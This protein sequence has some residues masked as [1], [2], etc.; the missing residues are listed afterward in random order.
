M[1]AQKTY[2]L[3]GREHTVTYS[4][5]ARGLAAHVREIVRPML[6]A[7]ASKQITGTASSGD[8]TFGIDNAAEQ[9]VVEFIADNN[10]DVAIYTEDEGLRS[11]GKP[12]ATLIIDPIDGTRGAAAGFECCVVS[13]AV[14]AYAD[15]VRM[16]NVLAG[17]VHEI[18]QDRA[19]V[20]ER[21]AGARVYEN[22]IEVSVARSRVADLD[23][24]AWTV[25]LA[26]RPADW[27]ASV[28]RGAIDASSVTGGFFVLNST[29]FSL[30]R[31]VNGQLSAVV[32]IAGRLL[33]DV[34]DARSEFLTAG[35]GRVIG[36]FPYDFAAAAF[37]ASE[38]GC[39]VTDGY[40]RSLDDVDLL[41]NSESGIQSI[42]AA[43]TPELHAR[44]VEVIENG[45]GRLCNEGGS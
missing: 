22:G 36:V 17:C 31:L 25:E 33:R 30:S 26:G 18:K 6:G 44:F 45:M 14:T 41:N 9:A 16:R 40:G 21:G 7:V 34:P 32:D 4:E 28:L 24:A 20:A 27:T 8:A 37:I 39:V 19:F 3:L 29:A 35:N 11:F 42:V 23:R 38:A 5:L 43:C 13:V 2:N 12:K 1:A 15:S 10:L